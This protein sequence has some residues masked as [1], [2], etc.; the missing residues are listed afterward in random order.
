MRKDKKKSNKRA[1]AW[2]VKCCHANIDVF[3]N[4]DKRF[5]IKTAKEWDETIPE[6]APHK[7]IRM[8]EEK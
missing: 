6:C 3:A 1:S 4:S 5:A 2:A 7:V 8:L